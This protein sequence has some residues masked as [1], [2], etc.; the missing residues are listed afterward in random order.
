MYCLGTRDCFFKISFNKKKIRFLEFCDEPLRTISLKSNHD[1][2]FNNNNNLFKA[3]NKDR[4]QWSA[5]S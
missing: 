2:K 3:V 1:T 4:W 5:L